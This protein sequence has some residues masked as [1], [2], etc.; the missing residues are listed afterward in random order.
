MH[1]KQL[2]WKEEA[3]FSVTK[4]EI[5]ETFYFDRMLQLSQK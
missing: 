4:L 1:Y 2:C 5:G 3:E